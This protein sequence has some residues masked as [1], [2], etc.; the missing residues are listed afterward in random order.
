[1]AARGIRL[2]RAAARRHFAHS[3]CHLPGSAADAATDTDTDT[4]AIY[5]YICIV[6]GYIGAGIHATHDVHMCAY[7]CVCV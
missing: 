7:V 5:T 2:Q 4:D 3:L 1:M 6:D